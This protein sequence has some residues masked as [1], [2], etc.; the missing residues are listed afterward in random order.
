MKATI[1]TVSVDVNECELELHNC[2]SDAI[3]INSPPGS[4]ICQCKSQ[5]EGNGVTCQGNRDV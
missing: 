4:F 3:C 2:H 1:F 5:F